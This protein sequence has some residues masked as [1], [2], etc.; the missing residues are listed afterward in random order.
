MCAN[1]SCIKLRES[2]STSVDRKQE[3]YKYFI[4]DDCQP[5]Q[6]LLVLKHLKCLKIE[7]FIK[8]L[9]KFDVSTINI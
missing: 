6:V 8:N 2:E 4:N 7:K 5:F 3:N 1:F 9:T